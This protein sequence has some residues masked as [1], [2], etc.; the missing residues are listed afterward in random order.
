MRSSRS[1][2]QPSY[3]ASALL[4]T[5]LLG[6]CQGAVPAVI[7]TTPSPPLPDTSQPAPPATH[8]VETGAGLR[9]KVHLWLD[10]APQDMA[11]MVE[12]ASRFHTLH[13]GVDL[14]IS[15]TSAE[16]LGDDLMAAREAGDQPTMVIASPVT[17]VDLYQSGLLLDIRERVPPEILSQLHPAAMA[18]LR[19]GEALLGLPIDFEAVVL[20]RNRNIVSEPVETTRDL[21]A[22]AQAVAA[23][24]RIGAYFDFGFPMSGG[25]ATACGGPLLTAENATA[26]DG[27]IG[28][29]WTILLRRLARAGKVAFNSEKDITDFKSGK[30]GWV[31]ESTSRMWE[32][33]R[34]IGET[35]LAIDPWPVHSETGESLAGHLWTR[36]LFLDS[37]L[38]GE[39][40]EATWAFAMYLLSPDAQ[41]VITARGDVQRL[42]ALQLSG[43]GDSLL[44]SA[45]SASEAS[46]PFP[47]LKDLGPYARALERA[48]SAV[49]YSGSLPELA[50]RRAMVEI[51]AGTPTPEP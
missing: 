13:P 36:S 12:L 49:I 31:V 2:R 45:R 20:Y 10:W 37:S 5:C 41:R 48:A 8:A 21:V 44:D 9:G 4:L 42:P 33:A 30:A 40:L 1:K 39:N 15:Y 16:T 11:R 6:A 24:N 34:A 3:L 23:K 46:L 17:G 35:N 50:L 7:T 29:C 14:R 38:R 22:A 27:P 18:Q 25:F 26:F 19:V 32:L 28:V 47:L 51:R 43:S